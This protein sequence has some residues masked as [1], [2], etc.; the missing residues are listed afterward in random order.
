MSVFNL[1]LSVLGGCL[2]TA[3]RL[4]VKNALYRL[5]INERLQ[6]VRFW[7]K[8]HGTQQDYLIACNTRTDTNVTKSFYWR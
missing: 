5:Q 1:D 7:G 6:D 2:S 8:V 3:Q 4:A